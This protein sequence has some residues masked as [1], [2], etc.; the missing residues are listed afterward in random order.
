M[1][2]KS[3]FFGIVLIGLGFAWMAYNGVQEQKARQAELERRIAESERLM[4]EESYREPSGVRPSQEFEGDFVE[5]LSRRPSSPIASETATRTERADIPEEKVFYIGNDYIRVH[6]STYGGSI[7]SVELLQY[8][9]ENPRTSDRID[10]VQLSRDARVPALSLSR[11]RGSAYQ[12]LAQYY[13]VLEQ[14]STR[15]ILVAE[16]R[17]G[18]EIRRVFEVSPDNDGP[19]PY[20]I[21]HETEF[22]NHGAS[23]M[24]LDRLY[25]NIGV[26][27]PSDA[28]AMG[29]N[30]NA[31]LMDNGKYRSIPGSR[32][33]PGGFFLFSRDAREFVERRG[34]VQ[35]GAVNNQFFTSILTP[36][37]PAEALVAS[38]VQF[39]EDA[40]NGKVPVGV[41]ASLEFR[42]TTL[43]PD[44]IEKFSFDFYVGP[45][46]FKRLSRLGMSQEDV[47][48]LGWFLGMFLSLIGFVA[49]SLLSLLTWMQGMVGNWGFAIIFTTIIIRLLLWPLTAKA[50]RASKRM[51]KLSKPL[52]EIR[53]KHKDN[54]QKLNEEMMA[55]WKRHKINPLAGC[56][57]VLV[58]F[59]IFIAFFNMLRNSSD[60]RF[61]PFL[62]IQ[63]LSMPD[64]SIRLGETYLPLVGNSINLLPFV[65][66]VSMYFQMKMMPQPSIDNAQ[67]KII[68]WMPFIFFPFTYFFSSGLVLY[69]TS[70]NCFSI[71]QQYI[72]NR[73]RDDEDIA[74]ETEI[75]ERDKKKSGVPSGPL[76]KKKKKKKPDGGHDSMGGRRK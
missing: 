47:M 22:R 28:D 29:F 44:G 62:W 51:Q 74:I 9:E 8:P 38:G 66:L 63:D 7:Q 53:E 35:W 1:D 55:L 24:S 19:R 5:D 39:P 76:I 2:K 52:Q 26:A 70:T 72:T 11:T 65:W 16:L 68:K 58:Q 40:I 13:R 34:I 18:L 49:K 30:L 54:P 57:P 31:S 6:L 43:S 10:P 75:E 15:V 25:F 37:R 4:E 71:L 73:T 20:V 45:K 56:W 48:Q 14:S 41:S 69:W 64:A 59:P 50:A 12:P 42:P 27:A 17:D 3:I 21:R 33:R 23:S 61:A 60:L 46:D 36:D 67:V 32:F